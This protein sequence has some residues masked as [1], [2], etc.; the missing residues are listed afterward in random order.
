MFKY[1]RIKHQVAK[2][3]K[4][5]MQT[6]CQ[7]S[8][9]FSVVPNFCSVATPQPPTSLLHHHILPLSLTDPSTCC[10]RENSVAINDNNAITTEICAHNGI[11]VQS[12]VLRLHFAL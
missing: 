8:Q 5:C 2:K 12:I 11:E 9:L 3:R 1:T 4:L 10:D 6:C 7:Q